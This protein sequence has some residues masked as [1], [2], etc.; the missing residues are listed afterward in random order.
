MISGFEFC[1][2][3]CD[4]CVANHDFSVSHFAVNLFAVT[5]GLS[6]FPVMTELRAKR[7]SA[8]ETTEGD[9]TLRRGKTAEPYGVIPFGN[10]GAIAL[11]PVHHAPYVGDVG[12][13]KRHKERHVEHRAERELTAATV[14]NR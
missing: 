9:N 6:P 8:I 4:L 1:I 5:G 14:G 10:T 11:L 12:E 3:D 2:S 13:D 7:P